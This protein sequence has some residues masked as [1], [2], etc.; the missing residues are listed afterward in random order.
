VLNLKHKGA[1]ANAVRGERIG[2]IVQ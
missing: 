1:I 2:T